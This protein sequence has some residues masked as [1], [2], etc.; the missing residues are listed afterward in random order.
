MQENHL[1]LICPHCKHSQ[2]LIGCGSKMPLPQNFS[3]PY[4]IDYWECEKCEKPLFTIIMTCPDLP[5]NDI[6][7]KLDALSS[8]PTWEYEND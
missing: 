7:N 1:I 5:D 2:N 4:S 3:A 8:Y 6:N